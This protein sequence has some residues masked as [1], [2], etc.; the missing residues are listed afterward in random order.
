MCE[1]GE[2]VFRRMWS[3]GSNG[4]FNYGLSHKNVCSYNNQE[5]INFLLKDLKGL[6][7]K[8]LIIE[9]SCNN[10]ETWNGVSE[11]SFLYSLP[12]YIL[13]VC[14]SL[15]PW[16][17]L[18]DI[19]LQYIVIDCLIYHLHIHDGSGR[20]TYIAI[21][22]PITIPPVGDWHFQLKRRRC[23]FISWRCY[24]LFDSRNCTHCHF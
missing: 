22:V 2:K 3:K 9:G 10:R 23:E 11:Y 13:L 7:M 8:K 12:L 16:D 18:I 19:V 20:Q 4:K 21:S 6:K 15:N 17:I 1:P 5:L 24:I 14:P